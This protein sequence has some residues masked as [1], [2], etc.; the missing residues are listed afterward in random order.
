MATDEDV[1]SNFNPSGPG[2][3]HQLF[4]LP[5]GVD[6]A[7]MV[8]V[9]APWE[10]TVSYHAGTASGPQAILDASLQVDLFIKDIPD[11]WK[12]G[13]AMLPIPPDIIEENKQ[14]R[15]LAAQHIKRVEHNEDIGSDDATLGKINTG[16]ERFNLYIKTTTKRLLDAGK[17]VGLVGGDH[18]T[19]LGFMRALSE[20]YDRFGVLQI[21]AHADLRKSYEGLTY[22]HASVM[23][24][25]LKIPGVG[26]VVQVGI[27]DYCE[28][29][30]EVMDRA[31]GRIVTFFDQDIKAARYAG[32]PWGKMCEKII[33]QLPGLVY[34]SF[35]I[36]GLDPKL[37]PNTGTPV[38]GGLEFDEAVYLLSQLVKSGKRII[39]FDVSEVS[40]GNDDWDANVGARILYQLSCWMAASWEKLKLGK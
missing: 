22:S 7:S 2:I 13:M 18:S 31:M 9:P 17:L 14:L 32:S 28:E 16:C 11:A 6:E 15:E 40:P 33:N 30:H 8:I 4:G 10:V 27:R 35:D 5:F 23:Y 20:K 12:L 3:R 25:A 37:C 1:L 38:P 21:D 19:A 39:G 26:K 29:E 24:N 36:D 34:I